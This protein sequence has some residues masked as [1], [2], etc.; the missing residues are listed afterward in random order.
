MGGL[1][2]ALE[3]LLTQVLVVKGPT[4]QALH[5]LAHHDTAGF[6]DGLQPYGQV[7]GLAHGALLAR[8]DHHQA[9]GDADAH[10]HPQ[11]AGLG[12]VE[13]R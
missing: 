7:H 13:L 12:H 11:P 9:G 8:G 3:R 6:S 4:S 5:S 2:D 1:R 10:P